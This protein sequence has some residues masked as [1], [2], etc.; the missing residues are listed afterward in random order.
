M[1]KRYWTMRNGEDIDVH[2]MKT[3]HI[4]NC[5]RLLEY[6]QNDEEMLYILRRRIRI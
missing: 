2:D 6:R 5:I 1:K 3:S 4:E